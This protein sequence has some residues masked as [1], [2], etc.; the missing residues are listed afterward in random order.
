MFDWF[1]MLCALVTGV[2]LGAG[3][4]FYYCAG[5]LRRQRQ[6]DAE[7]DGWVLEMLEKALQ[8]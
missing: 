6:R 5:E 4:T 7:W 3:A 8:R 1:D 2:M